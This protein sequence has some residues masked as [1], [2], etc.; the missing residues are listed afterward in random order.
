MGVKEDGK[1]PR[2]IYGIKLRNLLRVG[3]RKDKMEGEIRNIQLPCLHIWV[4]T[5][6]FIDP[7]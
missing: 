6:L 5:T 1:D 2:V 4:N 7:E 3:E